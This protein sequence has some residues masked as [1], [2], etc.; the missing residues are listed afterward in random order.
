MTSS[1]TPQPHLRAATMTL[2][3]TCASLQDA[4]DL[5]ESRLPITDKNELFCLMMAYHNTLIQTL[6]CK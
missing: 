3:P 6:S 5:A 4:V 2:F 1:S